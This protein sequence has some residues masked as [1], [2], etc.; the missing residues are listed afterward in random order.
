MILDT[1]CHWTEQKKLFCSRPKK[2]YQSLQHLHK[3]SNMTAFINQQLVVVQLVIKP[4]WKDWS[5]LMEFLIDIL[6]D[7]DVG[8]WHLK[9][10]TSS[11]VF[12][13][14]F[15]VMFTGPN[16]FVPWIIIICIKMHEKTHY[17][18]ISTFILFRYI[19]QSL[20]STMAWN[21]NE[22]N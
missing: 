16:K 18:V 13:P 22:E 14:F 10:P 3:D 1:K 9:V 19:M 6:V 21:L 8:G 4:W 12:P 2:S 11:N 20:S 17:W 7:V 5:S 15:L